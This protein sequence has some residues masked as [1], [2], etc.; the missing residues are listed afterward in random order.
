ME[1]GAATHVFTGNANAVAGHQQRSIGQ[2][3]SH[4]PVDRQLAL[5]HCRTIFDDLLDAGMQR[6]AFGQCRQA[7]RQALQF[8]HRDRGIAGLD[9]VLGQERRPVNGVWMLVAGEDRVVQQLALV[10]VCAVLGDHRIRTI[11]RQRAF[12]DQLV[13]IQLAGTRMLGDDLVHQRLGDHRLVLL[14]V[15]EL[16]EAVDVDDDILLEG[17]AIFDRDLGDQCNGFGIVTI[18]VEDRRIDHLEDVGTVVARAVVAR[19]GGGEAHLVVHHDVQHTAHTVTTGLREVE[20]F[21]VDTLTGNR[22]V[23][24]NQDRHDLLLA[25]FATTNLTGIHRTGNH[26]VDDFKVRRVEGQRQ[27]A[28]ASRGGH[29]GR[30][31]HVVLDVTS[32][33]IALLLAFEFGKEH[34]RGLAQGIDQH[35]QTTTVGHADDHFID[36]VCTTGTDGFIHGDDQRFTALQREALLADVLGV[37]ITFE[38]LGSGQ[39]FEDALLL[40]GVVGRTRT[41]TFETLLQP[42]LLV[43]VG[44]VHVLDTHSTAIGLAQGFENVAELGF[45]WQALERTDAEGLVQVAIGKTVERRFKLVDFRTGQALER[46]QIGPAGSERTV[47]S[48]QLANSRLLL[49]LSGGRLNDRAEAAVFADFGE[50]CHH[51]TVRHITRC[52][53]RCLGKLVKVFTPLTRHSSRVVEVVFVELFDER[54]VAAKEQ[55]AIEFLRHRSHRH[56]LQGVVIPACRSA[57]IL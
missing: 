46:I 17:L 45:S 24:V 11:G 51:R 3:L 40:F 53:S 9:V 34:R 28:R 27:V 31:A 56:P 6:E 8:L 50:R 18:N 7:L 5:A 41:D 20:H 54:R 22:R 13:T 33:Q 32:G 29:V 52:G 38:R 37:Q 21:L 15:A 43:V 55:G 47:G 1:E 36:A 16:A 19:I 35:I 57:A 39:A 4:A 12:G 30:E 44:H 10:E 23:T 42:A 48:D 49:V 25:A 26:R 2:V 14:V